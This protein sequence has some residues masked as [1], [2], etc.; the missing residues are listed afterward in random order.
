MRRRRAGCAVGLAL[1][2][3][4]LTAPADVQVTLNPAVQYQTIQ[5]WGAS[6]W[7]PNWVTPSMREEIIREVVDDL[8]LTRLRVEPPAGNAAETRRWEWFNDNGNPED[9]NWSALNTAPMDALITR[10]VI[11]FRQRVEANGDPFQFY[12]SPSFFDGGSSGSVPVWLFNSPAE[13]VEYAT[14]ILLHLKNT[15]GLA[16]DY[17]CILN[18][19]GNNN[20]FWETAVATMIKAVGPAFQSAGVPTPIQ[21]PEAISANTSWS[22]INALR[23]DAAIW[24]YIGLLS[25]HLYGTND[26]H[27]SRIRDFGLARGIPTAQTEYMNLTTTHLYD[28]LTLGGVS[29]WEIYGLTSQL[30]YSYNRIQKTGQYWPFRQLLRY[31]RPG[32]V[33]IAATSADAN[34]R[35]LAFAGK[36]K[37]TVILF[38]G[39]GER[40]AIITGLPGGDY[41]VSYTVGSAPYQETGVQ[42]IGA[43]GSLGLDLPSNAVMT[44]APH[45]GTNQPPVP[46]TWQPSTGYLI[47]PADSVT[48]TATA[49][50][51]EA[52]PLSFGWS[53]TSAPPGADVVLDSAA[54]ASAVATGLT[55]PGDYVFTVTF[56]D[57]SHSVT[58]EARVTVFNRNQPPVP[59]DVHNRN[60]VLVTLPQS[61]TTLRAGSWDLENDPRTYQ[62]SIV[63]QPPGAAASLATPASASCA[64]S[65]MTVPGDYVFEV[66]V[67][68]PTHTVTQ[69]LT[70]PVYPLNTAPE[71]T[72]ASGPVRVFP[73]ATGASLFLVTSDPDGD[74]ITHWWSVKTAPTG[75]KPA[76][77]HPGLPNA[78][79]Q[80]LTSLGTYVFSLTVIDRSLMSKADLTVVVADLPSFD[81]F[82]TSFGH[83]TG[84]SAYNPD[85]DFDGDGVV[86]FVDFQMWLGYYRSAVG[87][88]QA[89]APFEVLGDF[90]RDGDVDQ[91]DLDHLRQ[92]ETG[93]SVPQ[94]DPAC[95]DADLDRD[96]DVDQADFGYLQRC[97]AGPDQPLDLSCK[98]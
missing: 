21:F 97:M 37:I 19:A 87:D 42:T 63:S 34:L 23:N 35:V 58:R 13:Y 10:F 12:V 88:P 66:A 69:Q 83:A 73:P 25:Y 8:G 46:T 51:P 91:L 96:G 60:P 62:W 33:R 79:A 14:S 70:V 28:D 11:P 16:A 77:E 61:S 75:T 93:P 84:E 3:G 48:L 54:S 65:N 47:Q 24:P 92:C 98:Y 76:I 57:P 5:G 4:A 30:T 20:P 17:Y 94:A 74:T 82:L 7:L 32:D 49:T 40:R 1:A 22:F 56:S 45:P 36:S 6:P 80:G 86:T 44:L 9:T 31:V 64:A 85:T 29:V 67:S 2:F 53:V 50:D 59:N 81:V 38:N 89:P 43:G 55:V 27:R 68:D 72:P 52:D 15:H 78:T 90:Q 41:Q 18:E 71:I 39:A 95:R 26:P